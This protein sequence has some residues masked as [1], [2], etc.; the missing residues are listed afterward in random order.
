MQSLRRPVTLGFYLIARWQKD[1][2]LHLLAVTKNGIP[3]ST[4]SR[5][6]IFE[7]TDMNRTRICVIGAGVIG[8]ATAVQILDKYGSH[9]H[10]TVM[11]EKFS[12]NTTSDG[13]AGFWEPYLVGDTPKESINKWS[14][15][16]YDYLNRI[17]M[18]EDADEAGV[19][20]VHAYNFFPRYTDDP[21]WKHVTFGFRHATRPELDVY[22]P[23]AKHGWFYSSIMCGCV[24]Y[25]PWLEKKIRNRGGVL[26]KRK[27]ENL[28]Q[29]AGHYDI[30]V[31]CSGLGSYHLIDDKSM[32][33]IQ[34]QV[35][36][37]T[38]T[39]ARLAML[40]FT[41]DCES[42]H[43]YIFPWRD[44]CILGGTAVKGNWN[45][46][47]NP[48]TRNEI[49]QRCCKLVPSL[50]NATVLAEWTGLRPWRSKGVRLERETRYFGATKTYIVHNYGHSGG[51][52]TMHWGC[53][54][55]A[56][57]LVGQCLQDLPKH[58]L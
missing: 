41:D 26:V 20:T 15:S 34:G 5:R 45:D 48:K 1:N 35:M 28:S 19:E 11:S 58:K 21:S 53:A 46:E 6:N 16:T 31:N 54:E 37:V 57:D 4:H 23:Q 12:P 30:I 25:L 27:V 38:N 3:I 55:D 47:P 51:G 43:T 22:A 14:K 52:V 33:P 10:V 9:V 56:T 36:R 49:M 24:R 50:K 17:I 8:L 2:A 42:A 7:S 40:Y 18:S 44:I 13:S 39:T 29:L 32:A